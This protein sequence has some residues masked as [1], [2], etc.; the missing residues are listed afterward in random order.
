MKPIEWSDKL[1]VDNGVIDNDHKFLLKIINKFRDEVGNFETAEDAIKTLD[2]LRS[3]SQK[4]F[5]REEK[6][7]SD[8]EF[9]YREAHFNAH[10]QLIK[11]LDTLI[12]ET[13]PTSGTYLNETMGE[14]IGGFLHDWLID[15][16]V[17]ND[18]RMKPHV[19]KMD[20]I[21][22]SMGGLETP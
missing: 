8:V 13:R 1:S 2:L 6:L 22:S 15:H 11:R 16:V 18:L 4:H 19:E 20:Q 10:I 14:K 21:S 9:P 12:E 7:Q 5:S 17:E 3:Y